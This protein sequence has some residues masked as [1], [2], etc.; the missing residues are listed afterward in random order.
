MQVGQVISSRAYWYDRNVSILTYNDS[1]QN[2]PI[3]FTTNWTYTVP[4]NRKARV[5]INSVTLCRTVAA[6]TAVSAYSK[7]ILDS[8][9][10]TTASAIELHWYSNIVGVMQQVSPGFIGIMS[11]GNI[12]K[13]L[14]E[15]LDVGGIY[16]QGANISITEYDA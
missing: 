1:T 14:T 9:P 13:Y 6:T 16:L 5:S 10:V 7:I 2:G 11:E 4:A 12:I 15:I 8:A 3:P